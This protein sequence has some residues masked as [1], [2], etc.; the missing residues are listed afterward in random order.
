MIKHCLGNS[1]INSIPEWGV[2]LLNKR[3]VYAYNKR[4]QI[5]FIQIAKLKKFS[6]LKNSPFPLTQSVKVHRR[7][8]VFLPCFISCL[9]CEKS[10]RESRNSHHFWSCEVTTYTR[11]PMTRVWSSANIWRQDGA[12][13]SKNRKIVPY[14]GSER[15]PR[16][17][18]YVPDYGS[19]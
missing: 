15:I 10:A 17:S 1:E 8:L 7:A 3:K 4:E 11:E 14:H 13:C 18:V 5:L 2:F 16:L 12:I 19:W 9:R 6:T